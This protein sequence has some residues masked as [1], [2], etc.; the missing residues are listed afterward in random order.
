MITD[1]L[2]TMMPDTDNFIY[3]TFIKRSIQKKMNVLQCVM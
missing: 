2:E 3:T 1:I